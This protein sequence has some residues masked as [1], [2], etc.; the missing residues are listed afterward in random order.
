MSS[1]SSRRQIIPITPA[2]TSRIARPPRIRSGSGN[3]SASP[4]FSLSSARARPFGFVRP[5]LCAV[6]VV[7]V[8]GVV[9]VVGGGVTAAVVVVA[10]AVS[11]GT[12]VV[13]GVVVAAWAVVV[14]VVAWCCAAIAR[15]IARW[16]SSFALE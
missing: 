7:V 11:V 8:G 6:V 1:R 5:G 4:G 3:A 2:A 16:M 14:G 15:A 12:V 10:A 9:V 13:A